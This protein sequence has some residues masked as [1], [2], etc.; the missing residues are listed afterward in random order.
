M[1]H[2]RHGTFRFLAALLAV[3]VQVLPAV[4]GGLRLCVHD[5]GRSEVEA[6][7]FECCRTD[8]G[9]DACCAAEDAG[10]PAD[11]GLG[12]HDD[13][14]RDYPLSV[15]TAFAPAARPGSGMADRSGGFALPPAV[16]DARL[17]RDACPSGACGPPPPRREGCSPPNRGVVLRC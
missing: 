17:S 3:A 2:R 15:L 8:D 12:S 10:R 7:G 11:S 1:N 5:D 13:P 4:D 14:C 6:A 16:S 9:G